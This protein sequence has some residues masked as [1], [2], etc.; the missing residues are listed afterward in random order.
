[1]ILDTLKRHG[2]D[3][4][5]IADAHAFHLLVEETESARPA[6]AFV[7]GRVYKNKF[8]SVKLS[9]PSNRS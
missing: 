1:M 4:D 6:S 8:E 2:A 3:E 9:N 7:R 5:Q